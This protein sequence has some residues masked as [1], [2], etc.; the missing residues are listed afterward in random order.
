[1]FDV[2]PHYGKDTQLVQ[3][4]E[5]NTISMWAENTDSLEAH[6]GLFPSDPPPNGATLQA[7]S[8]HDVDE[9]QDMPDRACISVTALQVSKNVLTL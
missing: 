5:Q 7:S 2:R 9:T 8:C 6:R 4:K 3:S 1:M